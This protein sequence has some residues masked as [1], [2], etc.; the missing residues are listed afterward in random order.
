MNEIDKIAR[1]DY[2][3]IMEIYHTIDDILS[4]PFRKQL[5]IFQIIILIK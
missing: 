4:K 5:N 1:A 2:K 3:K